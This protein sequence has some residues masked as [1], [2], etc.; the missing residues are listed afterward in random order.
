MAPL[1]L[2][3]RFERSFFACEVL[4]REERRRAGPV[5]PRRARRRTVF[6]SSPMRVPHRRRDATERRT[7]EAS[8]DKG[9]VGV[10]PDELAIKIPGVVGEVELRD[11]DEKPFPRPL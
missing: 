1:D 6:E 3:P 11:V 8:I 4:Y 7:L 5:E 10:G 9:S 2:L